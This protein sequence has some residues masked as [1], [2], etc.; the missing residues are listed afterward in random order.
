MLFKNDIFTFEGRRYRF[1]HADN[2]RGVAWVFALD[3][4]NAWPISLP[5]AVTQ[6]FSGE[7]TH[8]VMPVPQPSQA[9]LSKRN[10]AFERIRPLVEN[11][12]E[13]YAA[14]SRGPLVEYRAAELQCSKRTLYKDLR[15]WFQGGQ[16]PD[17]LIAQYQ[18]CGRTEVAVTVRRGRQPAEIYD[19]DNL[20]EEPQPGYQTYQLSEDDLRIFREHIEKPKEGYLH[21]VRLTQE[22]SYQRLLEKHYTT[23]DGNGVAYIRHAGN[24][25]SRRQF[26]HFLRKHYSLE[27]R[28]RSRKGDKA[29]ELE[30]AAKIGS[31]A[32]D[33]DGVGH[34]YEID[35]TIVDCNVVSESDVTK[36]I[37]KPTLYLIIDRKSRLIVGFYCGLEN[38]S[39]TGAMQAILSIA[40]DKRALCER[41]G[42]KYDPEDWPADKV[43]PRFLL[44]DRGPEFLGK[45]SDKIGNGLTITIINLPAKMAKWKPVVECEFKLTHQ[46]VTDVVPGYDPPFNAKKRQGKRY[47][48]DACLT[49]NEFFAIMLRTIIAHN[50]RPMTTYDAPIEEI[51]ARVQPIPLHIWNHDIQKSA[52]N[53]TRYTEAQVRLA[54]LPKEKATITEFG[55]LFKGCYYTCAEA[56]A[57]G[58]FIHARNTSQSDVM[59][60]FDYRLVDSILVY[61]PHDKKSTLDAKL[62]PRSEK[63]S[64]MSFAEVDYYEKLRAQEAEANRQ[65]RRQTTFE[66]H[67][68]VDP[69]VQ[70]AKKRHQRVAAGV[71][72]SAR[73]ADTKV[74]RAH[75]LKEERK[76]LADV[77]QAVTEHNQPWRDAGAPPQSIQPA[78]PASAAGTKSTA[79]RLQE[80]RLRL[81]NGN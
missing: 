70:A 47:D 51:T 1:L 78:S 60:S 81:Q 4:S 19:L 3:D 29:F 22:A 26:T 50:R 9:M 30:H 18:N 67:Q 6:R 36:I 13:V 37:G 44:T 54:L 74:A 53:L 43:F 32:G 21:D 79:Q 77:G 65:Q 40:T 52:S 16:T 59:V 58:W 39:W 46:T 31:I 68:G 63:F 75:A 24:R 48:K 20:D 11:L 61:N 42:V 27:V 7:D 73:K 71:S 23:V 72:R 69:I 5:L 2:Y 57:R 56:E 35:A 28:L 41:Y 15:R 17:A 10:K 49:M 12:H 76:Q 25:P 64:G 55:I 66:Y 14:E 34:Y 62:T 80:L 38:A 8:Q 45:N 33:C